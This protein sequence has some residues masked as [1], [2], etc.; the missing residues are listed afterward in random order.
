MA[1]PSN[2]G[3]VSWADLLKQFGANPQGG[4]SGGS[5]TDGSESGGGARG[6]RQPHRGGASMGGEFGAF[7]DKLSEMS[8]RAFIII[9]IVVLL[10]FG[11]LL[12]VVPSAN[13]Y[14]QC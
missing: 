4:P 3:P 6:P 11:I 12:L 14:P 7:R 5:D 13:Q 10:V 8:K 1:D 2:Q 9:G